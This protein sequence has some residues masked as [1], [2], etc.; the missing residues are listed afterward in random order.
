MIS[1][2]YIAKEL[3]QQL[4]K[5]RCAGERGAF[6]AQKYYEIVQHLRSGNEQNPQLIHSR[7]RNGENRLRNCIKYGLGGG[8]RLITLLIDT[9]LY[10]PFVGSHD[11]ADLWIERHRLRGFVPLQSAYN[12]ENVLPLAPEELQVASEHNPQEEDLYEKNLQL[13]VDD[14]VLKTVFFGLFRG[15]INGQ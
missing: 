15:A 12:E 14:S 7:T 3:N 2:L 1:R 5:L 4:D 13:K 10:I 11:D 9:N 6:A 8:Y